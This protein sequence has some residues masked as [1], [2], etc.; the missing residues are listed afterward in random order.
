MKPSPP[1]DK[2]RRFPPEIISHAVWL[3]CRFCLSYRDVEELLFARGIT[4]TCEAIRKWCRTC[5]Q[6]YANQLRH[7]RPQPGDTWHLAAG[8]T[9]RASPLQ[10]KNCAHDGH[11]PF[12]RTL[13][14][15][16]HK[17]TTPERGSHG[18]LFDL[19]PH[20][21][22]PLRGRHGW[23]E[24]AR[25]CGGGDGVPL[26]DH[27]RGVERQLELDAPTVDGHR[28]GTGPTHEVIVGPVPVI[29]SVSITNRR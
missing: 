17:L 13:P 2:N 22:P 20:I 27:G 8:G 28:C 7:R 9:S 12:G 23:R 29:W 24:N 6:R 5:G 3:Y 16:G 26:E 19:F 4:V 21:N 11:V 10:R 15:T 1:T 18:P 14:P 25:L